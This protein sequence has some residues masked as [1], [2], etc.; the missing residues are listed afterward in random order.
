M[1]SLAPLSLR[2]LRI[3]PVVDRHF[4]KT[5]LPLSREYVEESYSQRRTR[6]LLSTPFP[7][8]ND[9]EKRC[10]I[11]LAILYYSF[12]VLRCT[13][14]EVCLLCFGAKQQWRA[15]REFVAS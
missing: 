8:D 7:Q 6:A 10:G 13:H 1:F 2:L 3:L 4:T 12:D 5:I 14:H 11:A 15:Q 9:Q